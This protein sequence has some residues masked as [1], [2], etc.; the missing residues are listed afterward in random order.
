[1][2]APWRCSW[3]PP[4]RERRIIIIRLRRGRKRRSVCSAAAGSAAAS[5]CSAI[6]RRSKP[7]SRSSGAPR[8]RRTCSAADRR[9]SRR[10]YSVAPAAASCAPATTNRP[11]EAAGRLRSSSTARSRRATQRWAGLGGVVQPADQLHPVE[12]ACHPACEQLHRLRQMW[13]HGSRCR[14]V[15][16]ASQRAVPRSGPK[17]HP[18]HQ[19]RRDR[20]PNGLFCPYRPGPLA[21]WARLFRVTCCTC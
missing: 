2:A 16:A 17:R 21:G 20:S 11:S 12:P 13:Q 15:A 9:R 1:V 19:R 8:P 14:R 4:G 18:R 6:R 3:P 10:T 5:V 7:S